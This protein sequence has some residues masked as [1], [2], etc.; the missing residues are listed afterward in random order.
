M[1]KGSPL[2]G[3]VHSLPASGA[4]EGEPVAG[5]AI[6]DDSFDRLPMDT[7]L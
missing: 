5:F 6:P 1:S 7:E 2:F 4:R 3:K